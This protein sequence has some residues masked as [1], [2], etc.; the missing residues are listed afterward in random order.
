[1]ADGFVMTVTQRKG[2]VGRSTLL[3]SLAGS[4]SKRGLRVLMLDLDPQASISQLCLGP[5]V[6]DSIPDHR[7]V[8]ALVD[9][10]LFGSVEGLAVPSGIPGVDLVP[11][12]N[13]LS[14]FNYPEPEKTG[15]FQESLRVALGDVRARY[16]AVLCDTPPSLESLSWLPAVAADVA[17]TPSPAESLAVQELTHASRFLDR[18]RWGKNPRLVWLGVVLTMYQ[19][20]LAVHEAFAKSLRSSYGN[21]VLDAVIPYAAPFKECAVARQPLAFWKPKSAAARAVDGVATEILERIAKLRGS[22]E[23]AA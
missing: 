16:D 17:L 14:R 18:V 6:I 12:S 5:E 21:L 1:M 20:R 4:L 19:P 7:S 3:F 9:D 15:D 11:G 22:K 2:G 8:C 23:V 13:S 10:S